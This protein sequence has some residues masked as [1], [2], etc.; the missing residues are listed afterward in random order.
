MLIAVVHFLADADDPQGKVAHLTGALAPGSH[1]AMSHGTTDFLAPGAAAKFDASTTGL[2]TGASRLRG[3]SST[4]A[5]PRRQRPEPR[6][7]RVCR[8]SAPRLDGTVHTRPEP[9]KYRPIIR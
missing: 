4:S 5:T 6:I 9:E 7:L 2:V 8:S 3:R 1:L